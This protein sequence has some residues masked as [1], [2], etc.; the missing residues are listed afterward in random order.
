MHNINKTI[1]ANKIIIAFCF[2]YW[3]KLYKFQ[4]IHIKYFTKCKCELQQNLK[5]ENN[6]PK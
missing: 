6:Y 2:M 4:I 3:K 1:F 5:N